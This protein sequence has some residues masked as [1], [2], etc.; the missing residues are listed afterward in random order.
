[1][2]LEALVAIIV[3]VWAMVIPT[4]C[5]IRHHPGNLVSTNPYTAQHLVTH[6]AICILRVCVCVYKI[7]LSVEYRREDLTTS[8]GFGPKDIQLSS[9]FA[10]I[11]VHL[12][13]LILLFSLQELLNLEVRVRRCFSLCHCVAVATGQSDVINGINEM[14]HLSPS[15][16]SVVVY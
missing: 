15:N 4:S 9:V 1:M 6:F 14:S 7:P 11:V 5:R 3:V 12:I 10:R 2:P 8:L 16:A 13:I